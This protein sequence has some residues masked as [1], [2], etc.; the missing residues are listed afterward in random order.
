MFR[1]RSLMQT[2][3]RASY[4]VFQ[5]TPQVKINTSHRLF[6]TLK[7][8]TTHEYFDVDSGKIGITDHAQDQMGDVVFVELPEVGDTFEQGE[9]FGSVESVKAASDVYMPVAGTIVEINNLV[10]DS[11]E[12]VNTSPYEEG[13]F[14]K[15]DVQDASQVDSLLD[16]AAYK[17]HCENEED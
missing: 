11:P 4:K 9:T 12:T 15:I 6:S 16:E 5:N 13:W 3:T 10:Q 8:A 1:V 14:V 2:T 7:F 17:T